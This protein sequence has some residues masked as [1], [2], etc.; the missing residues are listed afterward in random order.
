MDKETFEKESKA[1]RQ[2]RMQKVALEALKRMLEQDTRFFSTH[3]IRDRV[4]KIISETVG[5]L[6]FKNEKLLKLRRAFLEVL[7]EGIKLYSWED[8]RTDL[9]KKLKKAKNKDKQ[10]IKDQMSA[11]DR[12]IEGLHND[13]TE[14]RNLACEPVCQAIAGLI[15][16]KENLVDD[17]EYIEGVV[18]LESELLIS[19]N[20][21]R[22]V[23]DLFDILYNS[24]DESYIRANEKLWGKRRDEITMKELDK[25]LK[26]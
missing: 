2:D 20:A 1:R 8:E 6:N 10:K 9:R 11:L 22:S 19:V 26:E 3:Y 14:E 7:V 21:F 18:E 12:Q 23:E 4:T 16:A 13:S 5:K 15:L 24:L 25:H 17:S